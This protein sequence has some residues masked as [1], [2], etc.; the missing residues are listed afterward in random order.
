MDGLEPKVRSFLMLALRPIDA[1]NPLLRDF[2]EL[3][4]DANPRV[5]ESVVKLYE[6]RLRIPT[7]W[8]NEG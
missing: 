1:K 3:A 4:G 6:G 2:E 5:E 8:A 7:P